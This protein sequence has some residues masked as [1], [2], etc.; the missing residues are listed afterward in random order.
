[1]KLRLTL[2]LAIQLFV[3]A[4]SC[5]ATIAATTTLTAKDDGKTVSVPKDSIVS[6]EL[7]GN[8]TT[9]YSWG[10]S[11]IEGTA[12]K[13]Q[14][15]VE[16][17]PTANPQKLVGSGGTF[18]A[19]FKAEQEGKATIK[20][21]YARPWE[22]VAP[23]KV[24]TV[25]VVVAQPNS[26]AETAPNPVAEQQRLDAIRLKS[27]VWM[28]MSRESEE[29]MKKKNWA[30]AERRIQQ[31][32]NERQKLGLDLA[33]EKSALARLYVKAGQPQKAEVLFKA[34]VA[35]R[36]AAYGDDDFTLVYPLN[37]YADFLKSA[38]RN[39]EATVVKNRAAAIEADAQKP[40][41]KKINAIT[42]DTT[43]SKNE[44]A[45]RLVALGTQFFERDNAVKAKF[46]LDAAV[47]QNPKLAEAYIARAKAYGQLEQLQRA[48]TDLNR[49]LSLDP[50]NAVALADRARLHQAFNKPQ[51]AL[52]D[53]S[54][55]IA[56]RP[57]DTETIG[58]RAKQYEELGQTRKA[59]DDYT[60]ALKI[61]PQTRWALVQRA[62]LYKKLK[63]YPAAISDLNQLISQGP[64]NIDAYELRAE[65]YSA[66]EGKG[67]SHAAAD[68]KRVAGLK[69]ASR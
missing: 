10:L 5:L 28:R 3:L 60:T 1:M 13:L 32:L 25:T 38:G 57:N 16:Y 29:Y 59:I 15:K 44:K 67:S 22:K 56:A 63:D 69:A 33:S 34:V 9:G 65:V 48:M 24:F 35:D 66:F 37:E 62:V 6:V 12:V 39:K 2:A 30:E 18:T 45:L 54:A 40:P 61:A 55:S 23:A 50:K 19:N 41:A 46:A 42:S 27:S 68:L 4:A 26:K 53:F 36:E 58:Y 31:V 8:I 47:A 20:L 21:Q 7:A 11:S 64:D 49:A 51:L 43:L 17:Q 52:R 14:G